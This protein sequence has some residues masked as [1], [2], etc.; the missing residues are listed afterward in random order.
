[1]P[2]TSQQWYRRLTET[3]AAEG[4][5][6]WESSGWSTWPFDGELTVR[7]L[8]APAADGDPPAGA[9]T[10]S[11]RCATA[12]ACPIRATISPGATSCG[13]WVRRSTPSRCRF[14]GS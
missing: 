7:E 1:M 14:S 5:R 2:E 10:A 11:A 13:C 6:D 12:R 8:Q 4:H 9:T 3:I